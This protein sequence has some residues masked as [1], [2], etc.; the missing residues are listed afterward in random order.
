MPSPP[1]TTGGSKKGESIALFA[2]RRH[3][4]LEEAR[5]AISAGANVSYRGGMFGERPL[6]VAAAR[7]DLA[8]VKLLLLNASCFHRTTQGV[9]YNKAF[10][11]KRGSSLKS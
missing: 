6:H 11:E 3:G 1:V 10:P 4:H 8:V 7:G 2:A 9:Y 5:G